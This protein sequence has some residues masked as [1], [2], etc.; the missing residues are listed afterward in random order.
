MNQQNAHFANL[1]F[2][3]IFDVL[4]M[5]QTSWVHSQNGSKHVED[6]RN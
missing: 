2:N 3:S 1:Y 6:V 5:F 4:C